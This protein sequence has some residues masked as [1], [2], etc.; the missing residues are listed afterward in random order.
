MWAIIVLFSFHM[1]ALGIALS[2]HG[3]PRNENYSFFRTFL[4]VV[5]EWWLLYMAGLFDK[6]L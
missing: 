6:W 5:I 2:K 4:S 1:I 3:E